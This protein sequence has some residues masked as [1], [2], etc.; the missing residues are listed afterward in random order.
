MADKWLAW[1]G[2]LMAGSWRALNGRKM[3]TLKRAICDKKWLAMLS[4]VA[5][6]ETT[7]GPFMHVCWVRTDEKLYFAFCGHPPWGLLWYTDINF[8]CDRYYCLW[9]PT[10]EICG[11]VGKFTTYKINCF[12]NHSRQITRLSII[13]S[14][15]STLGRCLPFW[16]TICM[17]TFG[18]SL[19]IGIDHAYCCHQ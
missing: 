15:D 4:F 8:C 2:P 3:A 10:V 6:T 19:I 17:W 1:S 16:V 14:D 7:N 5:L 12:H 11:N 9:H 18:M 13:F